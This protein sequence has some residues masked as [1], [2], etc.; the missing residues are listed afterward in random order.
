MS[1]SLL[2]G[3]TLKPILDILFGIGA[4]IM[5]AELLIVLRRAFTFNF[6]AARI[7]QIIIC[8][9]TFV[10][11]LDWAAGFNFFKDTVAPLVWR[12]LGVTPS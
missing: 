5:F 2:A 3:S 6:S 7:V 9:F 8:A 12:L 4:I 10:M 11:C 1:E